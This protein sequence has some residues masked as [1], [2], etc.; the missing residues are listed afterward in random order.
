[1][2]NFEKVKKFM[3]HSVKKS[4]KKLIFHIIK[5][6]LRYDLINEELEELREAINR[7]DIKRLQML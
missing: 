2:S 4:K 5:S 1:M 7:K 3:K 6:E